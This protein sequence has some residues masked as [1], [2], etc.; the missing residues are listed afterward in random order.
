MSTF[1]VQFFL[2]FFICMKIFNSTERVIPRDADSFIYIL[3]NTKSFKIKKSKSQN[4]QVFIFCS[5]SARLPL[6]ETILNRFIFGTV[7]EV[8][9]SNHPLTRQ[10]LIVLF[11]RVLLFFCLYTVFCI[12]DFDIKYREFNTR[13]RK[14]IL[15]LNILTPRKF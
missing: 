15:R 9:S 12:R 13:T 1:R 14:L 7:R 11:G 4:I 8:E 5:L 3:F 2:V 10:Y 6:D